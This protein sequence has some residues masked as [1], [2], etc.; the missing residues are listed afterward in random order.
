[1]NVLAIKKL[2]YL[3]FFSFTAMYNLSAVDLTYTYTSPNFV[4][5]EQR[6]GISIINFEGIPVAGGITTG[7]NQKIEFVW[8]DASSLPRFISVQS[9]NGFIFSFFGSDYGFLIQKHGNTS[10]PIVLL[11][12]PIPGLHAIM[13]FGF[14]LPFIR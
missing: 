6:I 12:T 7:P 2:L 1:M 13:G 8:N 9:I 11:P 10:L 14:T 5:A 4:G 3:I